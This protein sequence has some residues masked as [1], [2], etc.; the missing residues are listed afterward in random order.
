MCIICGLE[1]HCFSLPAGCHV[2]SLLCHNTILNLRQY[3]VLQKSHQKIMKRLSVDK[4]A[5][6]LCHHCG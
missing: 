5:A 6:G 3:V 4:A 2:I 1:K